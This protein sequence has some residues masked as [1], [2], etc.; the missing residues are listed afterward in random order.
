MLRLIEKQNPFLP[1]FLGNDDD[2]AESIAAKVLFSYVQMCTKASAGK[3]A[4]TQL[5]LRLKYLIFTGSI[6]DI[7]DPIPTEPTDFIFDQ[8]LLEHIQ[9]TI[10]PIELT[11]GTEPLFDIFE[12][13][14]FG[15]WEQPL[16]VN[17]QKTNSYMHHH[18]RAI[19]SWDSHVT[20]TSHTTTLAGTGRS[21]P[22]ALIAV[23]TL[24]YGS[25]KYKHSANELID[26]IKIANTIAAC[27]DAV[28]IVNSSQSYSHTWRWYD[29]YEILFQDET[30]SEL[31]SP[32]T[33]DRQGDCNAW[34]SVWNIP[35][36]SMFLTICGKNDSH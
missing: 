17:P 30:G 28:D 21:Y 31:T 10:V 33:S 18:L 8:D 19:E 4:A 36:R 35:C 2:I 16:Q 7:D 6:D 14:I 11:R 29:S 34:A 15:L 20:T 1:S 12:R 25:T 27:A 9:E 32:S 3:H 13:P 26:D 23:Q 24:S 22:N 5:L